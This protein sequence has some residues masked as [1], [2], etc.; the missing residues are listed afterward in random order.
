M[1]IEEL[2]KNITQLEGELEDAGLLLES[3]IA[4]YEG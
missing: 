3:T 2:N 1:E 4:D